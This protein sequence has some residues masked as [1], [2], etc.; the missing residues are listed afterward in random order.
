MAI[1]KVAVEAIIVLNNK[2]DLTNNLVK[3]I[4]LEVVTLLQLKSMLLP[5][6]T[7]KKILTQSLVLI[8]T[9]KDM[10]PPPA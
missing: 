6:K 9:K 7:K 8:I 5:Q 4:Q 3:K 10:M 2:K 1:F